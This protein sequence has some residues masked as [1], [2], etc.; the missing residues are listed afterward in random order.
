MISVASYNVLAEAYA[1]PARYPHVPGDLLRA[2]QRMPRVVDRIGAL[3]SDV[4]CLQ[5]VEPALFQA[6]TGA[7]GD[8]WRGEF[9][10]KGSGRPDGCATF[11]RAER[12][13]FCRSQRLEYDDGAPG[14][15]P[16]GHVA[17]LVGL[18]HEGRA[19]AVANTHLRWDPPRT[20]PEARQALRQVRALLAARAT[21]G[22]DPEAWIVC[23]DMNVSADDDAMLLMFAA[24]LRDAHVGS[25]GATAVANHRA[26]R[27]DFVLH[28]TAFEVDAID[29]P[30]LDPKVPLP[31]ATEPSDHVPV[32]VRVRWLRA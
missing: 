14:H 7:L 18:E 15:E 26:R 21:W 12:V 25:S 16:S 28:G 6:M 11:A 2:S 3:G 24:G 8:G 30:T 27:I 29:L 10:R 31:N 1:E 9:V 19:F 20:A 22:V 5:E 17:L 13:A 4:V 32:S 23:G